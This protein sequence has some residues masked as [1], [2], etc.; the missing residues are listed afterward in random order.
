M[1]GGQFLEAFVGVYL[2]GL[3]LSMMTDRKKR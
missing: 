2:I 1:S 3:G